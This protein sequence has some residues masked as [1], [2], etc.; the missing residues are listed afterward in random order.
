MD[1]VS[2]HCFERDTLGADG[3]HV[4][5]SHFVFANVGFHAFEVEDVLGVTNQFDVL[6]FWYFICFDVYWG[7]FIA[8]E[9]WFKHFNM[10][11]LLAKTTFCSSCTQCLDRVSSTHLFNYLSIFTTDEPKFV[12]VEV[13]QQTLL[14]HL[15]FLV[16]PK[17]RNYVVVSNFEV[18]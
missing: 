4:C 13:R 9:N 18:V 17:H 15:H 14:A 2:I 3:A 10:E 5:G 7:T 8:I 6:H 11:M 1:F 16:M 12:L